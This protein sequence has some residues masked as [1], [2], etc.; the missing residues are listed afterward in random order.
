MTSEYV[1]IMQE[2]LNYIHQTYPDIPAVNP[3]G[4]FGPITKSAVTAFQ[5]RF[6]IEPTGTIGAVTWN[7]ISNIYNE[8]RFGYE[9]SP[10]QYAGYVIS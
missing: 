3:T 8:L 6:G 10:G 5:N 9:K 1:R 4:Y 7:E 2:Y